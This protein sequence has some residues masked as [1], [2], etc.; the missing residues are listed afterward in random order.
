[1]QMPPRAAAKDIKGPE[2][3]IARMRDRHHSMA[4]MVAA[5]MNPQDICRAMGVTETTLDMLINSTPAF[6]ELIAQYRPKALG[7]KLAIED[8]ADVLESNMIAAERALQD[9]LMEKADDLSVSELHKISRDAA[10]RLGYSK[11]TINT[12]INVDFATKLEATRRRSG[13]QAPAGAGDGG[14]GSSL[15]GHTGSSPPLLEL[16]ASSANAHSADA[17]V[18][19]APPTTARQPRPIPQE[20]TQAVRAMFQRTQLPMPRITRR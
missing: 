1:M 14:G 10:D 4:R 3:R 15:S 7:Q 6:M 12:N 13:R 8:Y 18:E 20:P 16:K 17:A 2:N 5:D 11:H 9:R 19:A